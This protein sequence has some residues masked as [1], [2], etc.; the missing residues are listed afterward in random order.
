MHDGLRALYRQAMSPAMR[1]RI[2]AWRHHFR[3]R[4]MRVDAGYSASH[5]RLDALRNRYAGQ[6]CF[7]LGNGPSMRG[8]DLSQLAGYQTFCLNRGYLLWQEQRL[9]PSFLVAVNGLVIEQFAAEIA[10]IDVE[11]FAPWLHRAAFASRDVTFFEER[12]DDAFSMDATDGLSS[13]ATVT[14]TTLQLAFHMG[15]ARVVLLGIDHYFSASSDGRP[16]QMIVQAKGDS[17]HFRDDYF[18]PG[19]RWHLPDLE[20]SERGY[21]MTQTAYKQA[22]RQ[23]LNATPGTKLTV[24]EQVALADIIGPAHPHR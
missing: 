1:T 7:I 13:L 6:T 21:K 2:A 3:H 9:T 5:A 20:L 16:H 12:W 23:V 17:D 22:G 18:A 24:F 11:I 4:A 8:F 10:A 19:T 14:N 15:F